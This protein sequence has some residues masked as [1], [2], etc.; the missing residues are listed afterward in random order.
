MGAAA[1][2]VAALTMGSCGGPSTDSGT[3]M[4]GPPPADVAVSSTSSAPTSAA[5]ARIVFIDQQE[6]CSCTRERI[7]ATWAALQGALEDGPDLP[8]ERIHGDTASD[9]A[10]P[11]LEMSPMMVAPAVYFLSGDGALIE[12]LQGELTPEQIGA[13]W[14]RG[15]SLG[16][17][18]P[19]R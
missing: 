17:S 11:F 19:G 3:G 8:V 16:P 15:D 14:R 9:Q 18:P 5:V 12:M 1:G 6:C 10:S 13:V 4:A 7:D 2:F